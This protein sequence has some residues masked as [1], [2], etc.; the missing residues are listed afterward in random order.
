MNNAEPMK[1]YNAQEKSLAINTQYH[2]MKVTKQKN[3]RQILNGLPSTCAPEKRS[4]AVRTDYSLG[5]L[6]PRLCKP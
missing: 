5:D 6:R 3:S 2:G 1:E 4:F